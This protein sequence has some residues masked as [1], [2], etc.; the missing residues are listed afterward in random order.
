MLRISGSPP[1]P[2]INIY[3]KCVG[4]S[5]DHLSDNH[6]IT[7]G[8]KS[9]LQGSLS[10]KWVLCPCLDEPRYVSRIWTKIPCAC[11]QLKH[12]I[13]CASI[14]H[15]HTS[16][17]FFQGEDQ[18]RHKNLNGARHEASGIPTNEKM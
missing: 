11:T 10:Q 4:S 2:W 15:T 6:P 17:Y 18:V 3:I 12:I 14:P 13:T 8:T 9:T 16:F 7:R 5:T 1:P